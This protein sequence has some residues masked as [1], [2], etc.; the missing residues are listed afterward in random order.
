MYRITFLG[1]ALIFALTFSGYESNIVKAQANESACLEDYMVV[2]I[3]PAGAFELKDPLG[4]RL[5]DRPGLDD[6]IE[7]PE[8][9]H[10]EV[11]YADGDIAHNEIYISSP[12]QGSYTLKINR[13][14]RKSY[15]LAIRV[16][17]GQGDKIDDIY[18][19][20]VPMNKEKV[21]IYNIIYDQQAAKVKAIRR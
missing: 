11:A 1:K 2:T 18:L 16:S 13:D 15:S 7:I 8:T 6:M 9:S 14:S 20:D 21:H 3:L 5:L 17:N 10:E 12:V 19:E 4:R